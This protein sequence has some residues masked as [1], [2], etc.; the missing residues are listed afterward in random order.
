MD[1]PK[2]VYNL[3]VEGSHDY[4]ADGILVHNCD[5]TTQALRYLKDAGFLLMT[6]SLR[7]EDNPKP[8]PKEYKNVYA[9]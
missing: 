5:T 1:T 7:E 3:T 8:P 6:V 9:Q 2:A 4:Y